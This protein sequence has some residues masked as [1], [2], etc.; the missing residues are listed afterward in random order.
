MTRKLYLRLYV[1]FL[2]VLLAVTLINIGVNLRFG[3]PFFGFVR[4]GTRMALHLAQVLPPADHGDALLKAVTEVHEELDVDLAV[5]APNGEVL[6]QAG[7]PLP[8]LGPI[9]LASV[10]ARAPGWIAEQGL[11]AAPVRGPKGSIVLARLPVPEGASRLQTIRFALILLGSL[12]ASL[13]LVLPL[14]R[15]ITRPIEQLTSVVEAYGRGDLSKRSGL[16]DLSDEVGRL[17]RSFDEMAD[18]ISKARKNEKELL[19]NVSHELRTPLARISV[20]LALIDAPDAATE[21]R[22]KVVSEEVDELDKLIADVLTASRLDLAELP[23]RK[24]KLPLQAAVEKARARALALEPSL[25][26]TAD[27]EPQLSIDADE[28]LFSRAVDNL[29]DNAR[30]YG[31]GSPVEVSAQ[32]DGAEAVVSVRDHGPGFPAGE[33]ARMFEPFYRG[34]A[35]RGSSNGFGLGLALAKRVA[36]IHGGSARAYNAEGGGARIELRFPAA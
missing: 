33:E 30:K 26:V 15:S 12:L 27:V 22:L 19:A 35:A 28:A 21:Q 36:E 6:A 24:V 25:D 11:V 17:A 8:A 13:V 20:A 23:L 3:R 14:S 7:A 29:L 4:G 18:R 1:A 32:R 10:R 31:G 2:G 5:I 16:G 9:G 34:D